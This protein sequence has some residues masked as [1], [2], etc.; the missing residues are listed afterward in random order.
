MLS[1]FVDQI[2]NGRRVEE[3]GMGFTF[4]VYEYTEEE[5][6]GAVEK[7]LN[8][9]SIRARWKKMSERIQRDQNYNEAIDYIFNY[10]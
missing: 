2:N 4:P 8:D 3:T 6:K 10:V 1:V 7:I 9:Q 5:L